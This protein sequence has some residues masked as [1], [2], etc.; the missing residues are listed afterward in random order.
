MRDLFGSIS[1]GVGIMQY[2]LWFFYISMAIILAGAI[3]AVALI[4]LIVAVIIRWR[5]RVKLRGLLSDYQ[6]QPLP[7][8]ARRVK[9]NAAVDDPATNDWLAMWLLVKPYFGFR[10]DPMS[11]RAKPRKPATS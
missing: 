3:L 11:V 6:G 10:V 7:K 8:W 4:W 5:R 1:L 9:V 2:F